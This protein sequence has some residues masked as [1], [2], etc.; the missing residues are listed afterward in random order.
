[1]KRAAKYGLVVLNT[2]QDALLLGFSKSQRDNASMIMPETPAVIK[3]IIPK[4][5]KYGIKLN[6]TIITVV[7]AIILVDFFSP[8]ITGSIGTPAFL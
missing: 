4:W 7:I 8:E 3:Y 5:S 6:N 1:M 2:T